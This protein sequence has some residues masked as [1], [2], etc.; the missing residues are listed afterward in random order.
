VLEQPPYDPRSSIRPGMP[1]TPESLPPGAQ[2]P[3]QARTS[4][5][6]VAG[7]VCGI[8][9][10]VLAPFVL[11]ILG[12]VFGSIGL[13]DTGRDPDLAGR[14]IAAWGLALGIVSLVGWTAIC[15]VAAA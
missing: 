10:I 15:V 12:I 5:M 11:G 7:L 6:A 4:G 3:A 1:G 2:A 14:A 9:G 13:R 8:G